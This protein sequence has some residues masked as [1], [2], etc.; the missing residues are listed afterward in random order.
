MSKVITPLSFTSNRRFGG[1]FE[2]NAFDGKSRPE[3][4]DQPAGIQV[5]AMMVH[6][7]VPEDQVD[8]RGYEHTDNNTAFVVKPDSSCGVEVCTPILKGERGL[9]RAVRVADVFRKE[10]KIKVDE[11][12]SFHTHIEIADLDENQLG[13]VAGWWFKVEQVFMDSV[14]V[15]RKQN[16]YCVPLTRRQF[17][18][19]DT[20]INPKDLIRKIGQVKYLA[21]NSNQ[22]VKNNR[23]TL[24]YRIGEGEACK[25]PFF[26]KCWI[27]LLIHFVERTKNLP[28]PTTYEANNP[29]SSFLILDPKDVFSVL[30]FDEKYELSPGLRQVR[31]WFIARIQKNMEDTQF[32]SIARKELNEIVHR[33]KET[34]GVEITPEYLTPK[35][36]EHALYAD[37]FKS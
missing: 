26:V 3:G 18:Q 30:G 13:T 15:N 29:M 4:R 16:R 24:E 2:V 14:P 12:C 7:A 23:K 5:I 17:L 25:D 36:M 27:R 10:D 9:T 32:R 28:F 8:L 37:E 19:H 11:R 31:N 34:E 33:I 1:E 35:N 21:Q 20:K 22:Y 6:S